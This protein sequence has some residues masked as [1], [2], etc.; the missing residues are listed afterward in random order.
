MQPAVKVD[1]LEE[2][3]VI[4]LNFPESMNALEKELRDHLKCSLNSVASAFPVACCGV[5]ERIRNDIVP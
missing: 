4:R 5:S 2:V 3:W 1:K